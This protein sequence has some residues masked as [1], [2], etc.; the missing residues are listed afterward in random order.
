MTRVFADDHHATVTADHLAVVAN[1]LN[2]GLY[3]HDCSLVF[4]VLVPMRFMSRYFSAV[5]LLVTVGDTASGEVVR[6]ELHK[7]A[8]FRKDAN[9][10]L[11]HFS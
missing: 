10:V 3:L 7:H 11:T 5:E 6:S 9:V 2:A 8:I 4:A 1:L